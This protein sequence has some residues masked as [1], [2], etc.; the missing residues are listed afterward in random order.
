MPSSSSFATAEKTCGHALRPF[1]CDNRHT[2]YNTRFFL[3][4][5]NAQGIRYE[6]TAPY[7]QNQNNVSERKIRT[8]VQQAKT[9]LLEASLPERFWADA[10]ALV[11]NILNRIP[12]K[13]WTR[14]T[15]FKAWFGRWPKLVDL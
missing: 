1:R 5:L 7:T 12:N 11:V 14:K 8:V 4:F 13:G 2:E 6:A 15:P 9:M 10:V 3:E